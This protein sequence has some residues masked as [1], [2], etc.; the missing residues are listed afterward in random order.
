MIS[1]ISFSGTA[2]EASL[3]QDEAFVRNRADYLRKS[4]KPN[5]EGYN[6]L[7]CD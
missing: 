2:Y 7:L 6:D 5:Y 4:I 3:V 1:S